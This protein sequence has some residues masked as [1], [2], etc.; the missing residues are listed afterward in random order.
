MI[1]ISSKL[2]SNCRKE[3]MN[4]LGEKCVKADVYL[5]F[6]IGDKKNARRQH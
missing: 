6:N 5:D 4:I 3:N 2:P 1:V